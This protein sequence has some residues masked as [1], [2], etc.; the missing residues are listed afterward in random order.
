MKKTISLIISLCIIFSLCNF[1]ATAVTN[2]GTSAR[3][4]ILIEAKTGKVLYEKNA[5]QIL[6]M[7][8]T[9]KIMTTLLCLES[10]NLDEYFTVDPEAIKVEGSSMGLVEGDLVTKRILCYGMMLPSGN[11]AANATAVKVAGSIEKFAELMNNRA[12]EIGMNNTHFVTPS[13]LDDYTDL[14]Y[15]TA[16]D[17]AL[18]TREALKNPLFAEICSTK[19]V[20]VEFGNPPYGRWL[21]NSNKLLT[22]YPGVIGV[23]TGF[24]DKAKRCLVSACE[25]DGV[26]L[27]CVTLNDPNDWE[28]HANL[29]DYGFSMLKKI[30]VPIENENMVVNVV[31]GKRQLAYLKFAQPSEI[32]LYSGDEVQITKK[33]ILPKFCYAPLNKGEIVGEVQYFCGDEMIKKIPIMVDESV[34]ELS[35]DESKNIFKKIIDKIKNLN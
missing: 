30:N 25:K 26:T 27:I 31:G 35:C 29:Y 21:T 10:G 3:S 17:M 4:A 5:N 19:N 13:G 16:Y 15:S 8:S 1:S 20:K 12:K 33:I 22:N 18:L 28:D 7:A 32:T 34:E 2:V 6:Q 11:D 23:K 14:H 9:T 24:T